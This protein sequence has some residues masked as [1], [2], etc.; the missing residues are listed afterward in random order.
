MN[1]SVSSK[2][3]LEL[4]AMTIRRWT[5]FEAVLVVFVAATFITNAEPR[6]L[7]QKRVQLGT[8][9]GEKTVVRGDVSTRKIEASAKETEIR[10][11][12]F[13]V[14]R[15][16]KQ[17]VRIPPIAAQTGDA[18]SVGFGF[19]GVTPEGREIRFRP[20]IETD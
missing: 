6:Q 20:V 10:S 4:L 8:V 17:E 11:N 3:V 14:A 18:W 16:A 19:I 1:G 12:E 9:S 2:W 15:W 13:I 5:A 7:P